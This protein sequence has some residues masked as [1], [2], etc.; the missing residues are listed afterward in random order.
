[1]WSDAVTVG[2]TEIAAEDPRARALDPLIKA[3]GPLT[4]RLRANGI[5]YV[6]LDSETHGADRARLAGAE[7]LV[8]GPDLVLYRIPGSVAKVKEPSAPI[9]PVL[10]AWIATGAMIVWSIR[11]S[12]ITLF[13]RTRPP[14]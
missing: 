1:V 10:F 5:R 7:L 3:P 9:L 4:E 2:R 8:D 11:E 13:T 6:A 12:A 14:D